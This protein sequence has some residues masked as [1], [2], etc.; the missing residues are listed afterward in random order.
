MAERNLPL[1]SFLALLTMAVFWG[2]T[3]PVINGALKD[4]SPPLFVTVRFT[5]ATLLCLPFLHKLTW[6]LLRRGALI[7][8]TI[9]A[10]YFL[11]TWG[12]ALTTPARS[13]FLTSLYVI[14]VPFLGM[15]WR[16]KPGWTVLVG[17]AAAFAG[18]VL[19]ARPE[20][21]GLGAGD[22]ITIGCAVS[23]AFQI[24]LVA[25]LVKLGEE[26]TLA[27][28]QF[29]LVAVGSAL[30]MPLWGEI[31]WT[32]NWE[33]I[34]TLAYT[35]V[36]ATWIG[37]WL[38]LRFQRY[39]AMGAAAVIYTSEMAFAA[40][41]GFILFGQTLSLAEIGGGL[42]IAIGVVISTVIP[43]LHSAARRNRS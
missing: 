29:A 7:G 17:S 21:G 11:Q 42:L 9:W 41:F 22:W 8:L 10:G 43:M 26:M 32:V 30:I 35:A 20:G 19:L 1:I 34:A 2:L 25:R 27:G 39:L 36:I 23:F 14:L 6:S 5:L 31:Y 4:I 12:L 40:L 16:E 33:T 38:Q 18:T 13:A 24:L 3:F 37:L 28:I 15:L